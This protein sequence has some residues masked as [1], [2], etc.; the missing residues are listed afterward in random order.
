MFSVSGS[1]IDSSI[2]G[3]SFSETSGKFSLLSKLDSFGTSNNPI[4]LAA[5][6]LSD[7]IEIGI[8]SSS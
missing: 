2:L 5:R 4:E 8:L 6:T 7:V 1:D 3:V